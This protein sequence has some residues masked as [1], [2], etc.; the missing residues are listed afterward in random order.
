V[1]IQAV[2]WVL[3]SSESKHS[4]RLVLISIANHCD[5]I[6][7]ESF[8]GIRGIAEEAGLDPSTVQES[9]KELVDLGELSVESGASRYRTNV[10]K[11]PKMPLCGKSV[12]S[13][14]NK[15]TP[16]CGLAAGE[17]T[18][19]IEKLYSESVHNRPKDF[20]P[21]YPSEPSETQTAQIAVCSACGEI[22]IHACK[23]NPNRKPFKNSLRR[24]HREST[25][26]QMTPRIDIL[27]KYRIPGFE[28]FC[29]MYP[30]KENP[31]RAEKQWRESVTSEGMVVEI[32]AGVLRWKESDRFKQG[33]IPTAANFLK[34]E[35]WK[36]EPPKN[37]PNKAELRD[38]KN[39]EAV[40]EGLRRRRANSIG[41]A[42]EVLEELSTRS[43]SG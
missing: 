10:Y 41:V 1:S 20:E 24:E 19:S 33:Y 12:R 7:G 31:I 21:S 37:A 39:V 26:P 8:P 28:L 43:G 34:E 5:K 13:L 35:R 3:D 36:E 22:G 40:A 9:I 25:K 23:G 14:K 17:C 16:V 38:R 6:G 42:G 27:I 2:S 30:N 18:D 4:A 29:D 15:E 11:L 32:F